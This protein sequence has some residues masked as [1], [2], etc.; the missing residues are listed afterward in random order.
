MNA[1][2]PPIGHTHA[3]DWDSRVQGIIPRP[4][5]TVCRI[6]ILLVPGFSQLTLSSFVDPLRV[7][8]SISDRTFFEWLVS[9]SDGRPVECASGISVSAKSMFARV[10]ADLRSSDRPDMI[11]VCAGEGVENQAPAS[12]MKLLRLSRRHRIPIAALGTATWLLAEAGILND[13]ACTIHWEKLPA[14]S[15]TFGRLRVTDSLFVRDGDVVTCAGEFA[16]FDL[17]LELISE[18]LGKEG[19]SAV[20]RHTTAGQWRS[21]S[22]RQWAS[23]AQHAGMSEKLAEVVRLMEQHIEDPIPMND[24]GKCIGLSP[25]QIERL[26]ERYVSCSPMRY[27]LRLRLEWA[28]RLIEQTEMPLIEIAVACGFV[29]PSHFSKC[30]REVFGKAPSAYRGRRERTRPGSSQF[31][32]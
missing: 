32:A 27:Y 22:E 15:E 10:A 23:G 7:A 5:P 28:R 25:R 6:V 8:N 17:A 30:F 11:V 3:F 26:F 18:N 9:S 31:R 4:E 20:F 2:F 16:S 12:L 29:S 13:N 21:G 24:I 1:M 19:A 14:L